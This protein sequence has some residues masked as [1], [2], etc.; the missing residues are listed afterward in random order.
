MSDNKKYYYIRIKENFYDSDD[1]KLLQSMDNGYL[2]S[3]I[4]MK[5]YL[6]S[7]KNNGR[8]M[9]KDHIPY[10][11]K[12]ISTITGHNIAIVE[13]ALMI[14]QDIGLIEILDNGAIYMLDIQNFIGKSS[15]DADRKR[16]FR[17]EL[18]NE[19]QALLQGGNL[20]IIACGQMSDKTPP[21]IDIEIDI[22]IDKDIDKKKD[23]KKRKHKYGE[24]KHVLLTDEDYTKLINELG[25]GM[26][27]ECIKYL[28]EYIE[29]KGYKAQNHY[30]CIKKWVIKAVNEKYQKQNNQQ[31][32]YGN[33]KGKFNNYSHRDYDFED[34][35]K[36]LLGWEE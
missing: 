36:K 7:L 18:E 16:E 25:D 29:M 11:A 31:Q 24:Y 35:E 1:I 12:M 9:F 2:Y 17:R 26:A 15:T 20:Q 33:N 22:D 34:L 14:F 4:L 21:E 28:D 6:K 10:N 23:N 19:K 5:L 30:L 8:L 3:D 32:P 13:K 27:R